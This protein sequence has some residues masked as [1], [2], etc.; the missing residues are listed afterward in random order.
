VIDRGSVTDYRQD[1]PSLQKKRNGKPPIYLDNACTTLVPRPVID[2]INEYYVGY[3]A[4]GSR[5]SN[6]WFSEEV[7]DRIEGNPDK[8]IK[9]S[10]KIIADF[11][12]A[13]S[14]K[15]IIFTMNTTHAINTIALGFNFR[16]GDIVLTT[17]KEHNSNLL[18][19]LRLQKTRSIR[20]DHTLPN[21]DGDFDL[22]AFE[23]KLK[24]GRVRLVSMAYT[25]NTTGYTIPAAEIIEIAHRHGARVLLDGAQTV[26]HQAINVQALDV[27]FLAFS[28]HKMCGP[29]GVGVL[30]GKKE[31][32]GKGPHESSASGD[33]VEP[34]VLGGG[35]V[36]DTTYSSYDLLETPERFEAGIQ[37]Y[38]SQIAACV[39]IEYLQ[40]IGMEQINAHEKILNNFLTGE[41]LNHYG[42]TGWFHIIGSPDAAKRGSIL[43]FEVKMPNAYGIAE[44]LSARSNIMIR[45]G[46]FCNHSYFNDRFGQGWTRPELHSEHRMVYRASFYFYNTIEECR[47]FL[48]TLDKIFKQ[49]SYL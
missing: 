31:L 13:S 12:H 1:F 44:E 4:C 43:T 11:I 30:Y 24:K 39:A 17:D 23:Q 14:E 21:S 20:V 15:E 2:S 6:H 48:E 34:I 28:I 27:D 46:V 9:G 40:H 19:W 16:P 8:G 5:R 25:S 32:L 47:I 33:I 22:V 10:R 42:K 49:R 36:A 26:P 7:N 29:R 38:P 18:P 37:D 41:L 3:P 45:S 35:I